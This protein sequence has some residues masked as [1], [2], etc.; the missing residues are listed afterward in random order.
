MSGPGDKVNINQAFAEAQTTK[1]VASNQQTTSHLRVG[2]SRLRR[3]Y[4]NGGVLCRSGF[5]RRR[6]SRHRSSSTRGTA[7][8]AA[9]QR[10]V[11]GYSELGCT[12]DTP[13]PRSPL[14]SL[15][16]PTRLPTPE[17]DPRSPIYRCRR[18]RLRD[19]S[20]KSSHA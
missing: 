5:Y 10:A 20:S 11:G 18:T 15:P 13:T 16:S 14:P 4:R 17:T 3:C 12:L 19:E 6:R 9:L 1:Q 7:C 2:L 8:W